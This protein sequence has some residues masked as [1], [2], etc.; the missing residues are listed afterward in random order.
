M[1]KI[2][3]IGSINMDY[4]I[5]VDKFPSKG[6]TIFG[7][8]R[9]IQLG[10]KGA[11]QA[12]AIAKSGMVDCTL[13]AC[14]GDDDDGANA[15]KTLND[16]GVHTMI[17]IVDAPT[18]NATIEVDK[19]SEN[20]I[21]IVSGAN[22][23]LKFEDN[24]FEFLNDYDC[25]VLQ[26]E[27]PA[28]TNALIFKK[29]KELGKIIIYNPAP[30]RNMDISLLANVDYFVPNEIELSQ[31][32]GTNDLIEGINKL[33]DAGVKNVLVTLGSKGS[34]L[35]NK[36]GCIRVDAF[37]VN[38]IDTVAAGDTFIGYFASAL[39][40]GKTEKEAMIIASK[41][42]SITVSRKGS[43]VSIPF[44]NEIKL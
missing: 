36:K 22:A 18:G 42:S 38:A 31:F 34:I 20:K 30:Y 14:K 3:V 23:C 10:G 40:N 28:E 41:A 8:G 4:T 13:Y 29:A 43:V 33:F 25:V 26:N 12:A 1:K 16:L 11:N 35:A 24:N 39:M 17:K 15:E 27:I 9:F 37:K 6:E 19:N 2:I 5:Y 7:K 44:G 32:T 21:I